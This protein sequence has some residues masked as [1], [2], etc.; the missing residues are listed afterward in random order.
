M[1]LSGS[2]ESP[3]ER[4]HS[5]V[6]DFAINFANATAFHIMVTENIRSQASMS[7]KEKKVIDAAIMLMCNMMTE[8][9]GV[10]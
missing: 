2:Y 5:S 4:A 6:T 7:K 8:K 1:L 10:S 9:L 3:F